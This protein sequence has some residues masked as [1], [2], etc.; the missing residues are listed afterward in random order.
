MYMDLCE[1]A[2]WN[3]RFNPNRNK[4]QKLLPKYNASLPYFYRFKKLIF[5]NTVNQRVQCILFS[6]LF[7]P[8]FTPPPPQPSPRP[9][10]QCLAFSCHLCTK[11]NSGASC[12]ILMIGEVS[13]EP[14][15]RRAW[16]SLY[17]IPRCCTLC[18]VHS[19]LVFLSSL[20]KNCSLYI[21][22]H[23]Y[24]CS[25]QSFVQLEL[26]RTRRQETGNIINK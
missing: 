16:V 6:V 18:A 9:T 10:R 22:K 17:L 1:N 26:I 20:I 11:L 8:T 19:S 13:W 3:A 2:N 14:K 5:V 24:P 12:H 21:L 25:L 7:N 23:L 15:R 4:I